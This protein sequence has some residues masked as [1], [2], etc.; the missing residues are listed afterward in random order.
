MP[1]L[2]EVEI[3][4]R[5]VRACLE[6]HALTRVTV[7]DARIVR[8]QSKA[9]F[10]KA[11]LGRAVHAVTRRGKH[12]LLMLDDGNVVWV[13]LGMTGKLVAVP[14]GAR[15]PANTRITFA[16]GEGRLCF[17]DPRIFGGVTAGPGDRVRESSGWNRLGVDALDIGRS[18]KRL[19]MALV[20]KG[21]GRRDI[22]VAL[23]D[24]H[25]LAGVGNIYAS[26]ALFRA[27]VSPTT[28]V[29]ELAGVSWGRIARGL[30]AAMGETLGAHSEG[31]ITY[32]K[33]GGVDNPF[34]VYGR[35]G[36]PCPRC[37]AAIVRTVQGGRATFACGKCQPDNQPGT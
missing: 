27:G 31:Q 26:E 29:G 37:G 12:L 20:P 15:P 13:H 22:K 10:R 16:H 21:V 23:M 36:E 3:A 7:H 2:P 17:R 30:A 33:E 9:A 4:A 6:G 11:V 24:Q 34:L 14:N 1:E 28:P 25:R 8:K 18:G 35:A 32:L 19:R 5:V